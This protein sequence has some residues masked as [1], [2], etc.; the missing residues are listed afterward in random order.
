MANT[1]KSKNQ[2]RR[3]VVSLDEVIENIKNFNFELATY[4]DGLASEKECYV[5]DNLAH[6]RAWYAIWDEN[7]D[8]YLF[9]PSKYIG[10]HNMDSEYYFEKNKMMD[11]RKTEKVLSQWFEQL[12][13]S[14][15]QFQLLNHELSIIFHN[16]GKTINSL[17]RIN[18][19]KRENENNDELLEKDLVELIYKVFLS[20]ADENKKVIKQKIINK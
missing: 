19:I 8:K 7:E 2:N 4:E 17:F 13:E 16:T 14:E 1:L 11:G 6:Y 20:L 15:E 5:M 9:A 10:Y 3:M 18:V 12:D